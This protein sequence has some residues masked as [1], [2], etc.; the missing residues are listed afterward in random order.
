MSDTRHETLRAAQKKLLEAMIP[1]ESM[2]HTPM[3]QS[4]LGHI[5]SLHALVGTVADLYK[6]RLKGEGDGMRAELME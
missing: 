3:T 2:E 6:P 4:L 5:N 1:L